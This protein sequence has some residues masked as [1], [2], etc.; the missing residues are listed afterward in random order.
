MALVEREA[1]LWGIEIFL[2]LAK[3][4]EAQRVILEQKNMYIYNVQ[5][6]HPCSSNSAMF[7]FTLFGWKIVQ[8]HMASYSLFR[9][10]YL[11]VR[12]EK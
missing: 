12:M 8:L 6:Y 7:S 1:I 9:E 11:V 4:I 5:K 10:C 2:S 3:L